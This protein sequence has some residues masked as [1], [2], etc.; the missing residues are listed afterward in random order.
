MLTAL[1]GCSVERKSAITTQRRLVSPFPGSPLLVVVQSH[2]VQQVV[3]SLWADLKPLA[4]RECR[5]PSW[6]KFDLGATPGTRLARQVRSLLARL[7][8][9]GA[10]PSSRYERYRQVH[11]QSKAAA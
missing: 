9:R 4:A 7:V 2:E 1:A 10:G 5:W 8:S 11:N 3:R 6:F